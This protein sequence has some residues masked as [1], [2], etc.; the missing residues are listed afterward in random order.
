M[1]S[2]G[3]SGEQGEV[4]GAGDACSVSKVEGGEAGEELLDGA[5]GW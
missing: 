3:E 2:L 1:D 5:V 4:D